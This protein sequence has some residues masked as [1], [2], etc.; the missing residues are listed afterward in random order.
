MRL[1]ALG[2]TAQI[3]RWIAEVLNERYSQQEQAS[4]ETPAAAVGLAAGTARAIAGKEEEDPLRTS[5][6]VSFCWAATRN[7]IMQAT[8]GMVVSSAGASLPPAPAG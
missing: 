2:G 6:S 4:A 1:D 8:T 5:A 3:P 7:I